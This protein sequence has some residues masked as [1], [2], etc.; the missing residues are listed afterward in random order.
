MCLPDVL[1]PANVDDIIAT[2]NAAEPKVRKTILGI[3]AH[4]SSR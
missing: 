3:L 2:A 4:E 1:K